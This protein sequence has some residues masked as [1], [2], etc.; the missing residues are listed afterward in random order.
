MVGKIQVNLSLSLRKVLRQPQYLY[1]NMLSDLTK[2]WRRRPEGN[3]QQAKNLVA[4]TKF[5]GVVSAGS[6]A[7]SFLFVPP[8]VKSN[9]CERSCC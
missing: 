7:V 1:L 2:Y 3:S 8:L 6:F 9:Y 4:R 5:G